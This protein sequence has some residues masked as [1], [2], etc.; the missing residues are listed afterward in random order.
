VLTGSLCC[1]CLC[2]CCVQVPLYT[3]GDDP[4]AKQFR[5]LHAVQRHMVDTNQCRWVVECMIYAALPA[6]AV[7]SAYVNN[8]DPSG[9]C[10][11]AVLV[12]CCSLMV[13]TTFCTALDCTA[14]AALQN[15]V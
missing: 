3:A 11:P 9:L 2:C 4:N 15:A 1:R 14:A 13:V 6:D 5:S 10:M 12:C 7:C 8:V